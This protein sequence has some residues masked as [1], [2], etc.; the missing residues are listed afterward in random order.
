MHHY[1]THLELNTLAIEYTFWSQESIF[2]VISQI[3]ECAK[4]KTSIEFELKVILENRTCAHCNEVDTVL[5]ST[6]VT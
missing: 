6:V 4:N 1:N 5:I 3:K 2:R